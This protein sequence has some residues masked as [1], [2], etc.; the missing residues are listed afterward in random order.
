[1][2]HESARAAH[3]TGW[4]LLLTLLVN[5]QLYLDYPGSYSL[6]GS[7]QWPCQ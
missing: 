6:L 1:M 3:G 2:W 4:A 5:L 7:D